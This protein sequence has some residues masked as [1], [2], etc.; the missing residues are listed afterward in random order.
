MI[1]SF[2]VV[3]R[4]LPEHANNAIHTDAGAQAA[5]FPSALVAGV[6]TYAYLCRPALDAWG[7]AWAETGSGE[8]R[9]RAPV[10]AGERIE[11][12]ANASGSGI[13]AVGDGRMRAEVITGPPSSVVDT[14]WF[15]DDGEPI[16]PH[17]VALVGEFDAAYAE[18]AGDDL[19]LCRGAG[20]MHP[21]VWPALANYVFH[22]ELVTGSWIHTRTRFAHVAL[23]PNGAT[24]EI[25]GTVVD[26]FH[27]S[28]E[29]AVAHFEITVDGSLVA[30]LEHE[31]IV[32]L[33]G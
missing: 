11:C 5:G 25:A 16:P 26:R 27:R 31:A 18:K 17:R 1:R 8:V 30:V 10:L 21:A 4:N 3:A 9:F 6:T 7:L 2:Q 15:R 32:N 22:R 13:A 19:T 23:A 29:R 33:A 20:V 28:G 14:S 12:G 24:A